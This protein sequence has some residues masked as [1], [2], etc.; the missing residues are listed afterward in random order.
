[1]ATTFA[2]IKRISMV[3]FFCKKKMREK[4]EVGGYFFLAVGPQRLCAY[5]IMKKVRSEMRKEPEG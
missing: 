1:M 5:P 4:R 3:L 2:S